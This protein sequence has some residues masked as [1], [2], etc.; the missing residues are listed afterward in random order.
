MKI[1]L[2]ESG[3]IKKNLKKWTSTKNVF[4]IAAGNWNLTTLAVAAYEN[5]KGIPLLKMIT[6]ENI[7]FAVQFTVFHGKVAF[8]F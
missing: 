4:R 3:K 7:V 8:C 6:S 2:V 1:F 5:M